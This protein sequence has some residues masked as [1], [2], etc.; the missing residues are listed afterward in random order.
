M[1]A[2]EGIKVRADAKAPIV[3]GGETMGGLKA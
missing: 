2:L 1:T 3:D